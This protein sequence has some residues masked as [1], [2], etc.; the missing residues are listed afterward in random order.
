MGSKGFLVFLQNR[1][2]LRI[3]T[4]RVMRRVPISMLQRF[5]TDYGGW[6]LPNWVFDC[7]QEI[8]VISAGLGHD[9]SFDYELCIRGAK[10]VGVDPLPECVSDSEEYL[11]GFNFTAV[12]AGL[13][14][15]DGVQQFFAPMEESHDSW[16]LTNTQGTS[17]GNSQEMKVVSIST[18]QNYFSS[19]SS[20]R[21]LKMDIEG[22]E[23]LVLPDVAKSDF[24]FDVLLAE[25]DFLSLI[26]FLSIKKRLQKMKLAGLLLKSLDRNGYQLIHTENFNFLWVDC[27]N[28]DLLRSLNLD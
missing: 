7:K 3:L 10:V 6:W 9:V 27:G 11:K 8:Q 19:E 22:A 26:P 21:I 12:E 13:S 5:G 17:Q 15:F 28:R 1:I 24:R 2:V 16:S 20:F 18:L 23:E 14:T 4:Y 25:L